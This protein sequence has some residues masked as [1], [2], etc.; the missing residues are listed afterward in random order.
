MAAK[1]RQSY[2][3][4]VA[5]TQFGQRK[6][7]DIRVRAYSEEGARTCAIRYGYNIVACRKYVKAEYHQAPENSGFKISALNLRS[8]EKLLGLTWPIEIKKT[9][10]KGGRRGCY[11][12]TMRN[13]RYVHAIT[14]KSWLDPEQAGRTLFHELTHGLQAEREIIKHSNWPAF[15]RAWNAKYRDGTAYEAKPQEIEA[16]ANEALNDKYPLAKSLTG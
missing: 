6:E 5:K 10:H 11:K 1:R 13:G 12:P 14:I 3:L 8:A 16:R 4:R 9:S 7:E 2:I 15:V